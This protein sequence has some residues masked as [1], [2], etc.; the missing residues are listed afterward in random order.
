MTKKSLLEKTNPLYSQ[1]P[2]IGDLFKAWGEA[3]DGTRNDYKTLEN[4]YW[5]DRVTLEGIRFWEALLDYKTDSLKSLEDRRAALAARW[6]LDSKCDMAMLQAVANS[7]KNAETE[8]S[9][10]QGYID[11]KFRS[12]YGIPSDLE[13]LKQA[14]EYTK[15]AHLPIRYAYKYLTVGEVSQM[16]IADLEKQP[17]KIFAM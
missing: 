12:S 14:L 6:K 5:L 16:T 17:L 13:E 8:I 4:Q 11:V 3:I 2:F 9:F 10:D 15:P 1:D 7:W